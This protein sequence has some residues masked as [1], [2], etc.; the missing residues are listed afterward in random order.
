M[1]DVAERVLEGIV[2]R[3]ELL[4]RENDYKKSKQYLKHK[5][6]GTRWHY[7]NNDGVGEATVKDSEL[8]RE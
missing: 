5:T 1:V 4:L 8:V 3:H 7:E 2:E 6:I